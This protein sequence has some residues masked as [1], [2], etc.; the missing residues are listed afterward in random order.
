MKRR[1]P[2]K[3]KFF[4]V[5]SGNT[6]GSHEELIH[7]L[8]AKR[9]L[10]E[11]TSLEESDVILAF[12]PI[13]SRAGTDVEAAMQQ[14][15]AGKP[16]ILVVLHHTF[17]SDYTVPDSSRLVTREDVILTV[18]C[19]FHESK[20][21]LKCPR[22]KEASRKILDRPE[23]QPKKSKPAAPGKTRQIPP[24]ASNPPE[25]AVNDAD[26]C[27]PGPKNYVITRQPKQQDYQTRS[28]MDKF[29]PVMTGNT[30]GSHKELINRLAAKRHL[31]EV[32][33][34]EE[35]DVILAFC[36]IV[37]RAGTDVEAALQQIPA[38]K[39]VILVVLHHTFDS[40]YTVPDSSRRVTRGDVILTV[41]CLFHESKG[42]LKCPRNK[43]AIR[44]ILDRPEIQPK[45]GKPAAPEKTRQIPPAASNPPEDTTNKDSGVYDSTTNRIKHPPGP[46]NAENMLRMKKFFTFVAG[47]TLGSHVEFNHRL[48]TKRGLT[49]VMSPEQSDVILSFCPIVSRAGTTIEAALQQ[50]PAGKPVILVVLHHTFNPD[51]TVPDS[52]RRVTRGDV[53]L[54]VDCLF[55]ESKGLLKCPR[56]EEA[57]RKILD[58]PEIQ[59]KV[60]DEEVWELIRKEEASDAPEQEN[61]EARTMSLEEQI[62]DLSPFAASTLARAG[63]KEDIDIQE[64]T[65][66]DLNEL[67]PG[68]EHFKL[69][70]KISALLTQSKQDTAK[71]IDL[72]LN[73]FREFLPAVVMKNAL[74]PGGVLH[75]YVPI[76]KD[77]EKQL[78]KALH[79]IQAHVE[80]LE[81]YN[82]EEPME[83]EANAV[84][85]SADS[86]TAGNQL[87]NVA[88]LGAVES[89]PKRPRRDVPLTTG[90]Q[91]SQNFKKTPDETSKSYL[92]YTSGAAAVEPSATSYKDR[93]SSVAGS[94]QAPKE[95]EGKEP[96]S[97][98]NFQWILRK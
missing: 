76:L 38:G 51:D 87:S 49:E 25:D 12:C 50:I 1:E 31:T 45:T 26:K 41:D 81:S 36:P 27:R 57:I 65:R 93:S 11:V 10:T 86:A 90:G 60:Q 8:A 28:T 13:V 84:S 24:A 46:K 3:K 19:L 29:F 80:L 14:I 82:E 97:L 39:P 66:D 15:P 32:T 21:L 67:L 53:I 96:G 62:R 98:W 68:L 56:N 5:V 88:A 43:E 79:F 74:V 83:A 4:T 75:G 34:P 6:L 2:R 94:I 42:L 71:P 16:A 55:N 58:R 91:N 59:P 22:N 33:S 64:L 73:E 78:A 37:S 23:I 95:K 47:N 7:R 54:T 44:K 9:H 35:S 30:L 92:P 61:L 40:D 63:I 20:G 17:D 89:Q 77:L 52:S 85:P 18:D 70:K 72:I 69:R 48:N